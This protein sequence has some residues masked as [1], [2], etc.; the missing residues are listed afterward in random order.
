MRTL[1]IGQNDAGQRLDKFL[2]KALPRMPKSLLY[3]SI[4]IKK[5]KVNRKRA[6]PEQILAEGDELQL[7]LPDD[8]F[9]RMGDADTASPGSRENSR[10]STR[11]KT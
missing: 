7:F 3:K 8:L 6:A 10:S 4:R 2:T 9:D 1:T 5:I 11:T